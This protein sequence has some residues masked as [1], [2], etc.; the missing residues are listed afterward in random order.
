MDAEKMLEN[1]P[2]PDTN[3]PEELQLYILRLREILQEIIKEIKNF[4]SR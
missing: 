2:I 3:N 4:E 1:L